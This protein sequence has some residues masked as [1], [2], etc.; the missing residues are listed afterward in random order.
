SRGAIWG[1]AR[2]RETKLPGCEWFLK[3]KQITSI[4]N[5]RDDPWPEFLD[6]GTVE[7][8]DIERWSQSDDGEIENDFIQLLQ[9]CLQERLYRW[10]I[11]YSDSLEFFYFLSTFNKKARSIL[12]P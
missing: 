7:E 11:R 3:S 5:L 9:L 4:Y 12:L 10:G 8:F 6:A 1:L 2:E